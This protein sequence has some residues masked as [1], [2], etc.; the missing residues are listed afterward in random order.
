MNKA[1][2]TFRFDHQ[3]PEPSQEEKLQVL[4]YKN[5]P[6]VNDLQDNKRRISETAEHMEHIQESNPDELASAN[7]RITRRRFAPALR[8]Q[9]DG[10]I[11]SV[12]RRLPGQMQ[13]S[14]LIVRKKREI[15]RLI[16]SVTS[17]ESVRPTLPDGS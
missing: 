15:G 12:I 13:M 4:P 6:I 7:K 11:P 1:K 10:T 8:A 9:G 3:Q 5:R 17:T 2:M 16:I 14:C